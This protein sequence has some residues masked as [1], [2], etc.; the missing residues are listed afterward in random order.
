M[1]LCTIQ[2]M[3]VGI[4]AGGSYSSHPFADNEIARLDYIVA[5]DGGAEIVLQLGLQPNVVIGDMDSLSKKSR[6]IL[7]QRGVQFI[8]FTAEKDETDTELALQHAV[9]KGA[10]EITLFGGSMGD[11]IDHVLANILLATLSPVTLQF[12]NGN[13][14]AWMVKG[15]V[16]CSISGKKGDLLSLI[17]INGDVLGITSYGLFYQ[18]HNDRLIF[19]KSRGISNVFTKRKI[20]LIIKNGT[21]LVVQTVV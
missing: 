17:P 14:V 18:L 7:Q 16:A 2:H 20:S 6:N 3:R 15:P 19:G 21:C 5:A 4:F 9:K 8:E 13:Q 11:R 12:V 10:T 1:Y